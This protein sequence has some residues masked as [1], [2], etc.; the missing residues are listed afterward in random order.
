MSPPLTL[1][2]LTAGLLVGSLGV[3]YRFWALLFAVPFIFAGFGLV[4]G[5]VAKKQLG[6][7]WLS[8]F[9]VTWF[10]LDPLKLLLLFAVVADSW[11]DIRGRLGKA[12]P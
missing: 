9:Y 11:I 12:T 3:D 1:A 10:L 5:I 8:L 4:H 7:N 2:L 6:G